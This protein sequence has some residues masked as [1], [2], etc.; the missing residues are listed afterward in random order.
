M[1]DGV[2]RSVLL[3]RLEFVEMVG[4]DKLRLFVGKKRGEM[5]HHIRDILTR[6]LR[7]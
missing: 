6:D 5:I 1:M 7:V 2:E 3:A 4:S